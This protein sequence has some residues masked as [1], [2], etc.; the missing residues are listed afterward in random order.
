MRSRWLVY[1]ETWTIYNA[2]AQLCGLKFGPH[3]EWHYYRWR[4]MARLSAWSFGLPPP[5]YIAVSSAKLVG[6]VRL[7]CA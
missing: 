7:K 5:G 2:Y 1:V 6:L 3:R 4:W